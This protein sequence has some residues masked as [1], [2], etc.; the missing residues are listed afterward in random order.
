M[1][2][3]G[4]NNPTMLLYP[5]YIGVLMTL[6]V[7]AHLVGSTELTASLPIITWKIKLPSKIKVLHCYKGCIKRSGQLLTSQPI[8]QYCSIVR[9]NPRWF[10]LNHSNGTWNFEKFLSSFKWIWPI[11]FKNS[12]LS[13]WFTEPISLATFFPTERGLIDQGRTWI[14][15]KLPSIPFH[16]LPFFRASQALLTP[17][18]CLS[19][20]FL[21][22]LLALRRG[23]GSLVLLQKSWRLTRWE[24]T[25]FKVGSRF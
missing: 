6:L 16:L 4:Y 23:G 11:K 21:T 12:A 20:A 5:T 14:Q 13:H 24:G 22:F 2:N 8:S 18:Q 1:D 3:L 25:S 19:L 17:L 7:G 9:K 15:I 10:V